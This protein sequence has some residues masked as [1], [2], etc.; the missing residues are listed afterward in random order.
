[1][2]IMQNIKAE[3]TK[4][5]TCLLY[6]KRESYSFHPFSGNTSLYSKA[7]TGY[8]TVKRV[9]SYKKTFQEVMNQK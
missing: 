8:K 5:H 6:S 7:K 9:N 3:R 1:M 2:N 4:V